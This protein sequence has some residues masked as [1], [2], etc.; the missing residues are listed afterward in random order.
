MAL[1]TYNAKRDFKKTSEPSGKPPARKAKGKLRFVV[2]KHDASHLHYDFRLEMEGVLRSWAV[3]KGFPT[4]KGDKRLAVHVEDH[5]MAYR[6]FEGTIPAGN[7]GGGTVMVW[8]TGTYEVFGTDPV[9]AYREGKL[10]LQL[11]GGKLTGEWTL[12]AMRGRGEKNW[13]LLKSGESVKEFTAA[14]EN[15]SSKTRR[16]FEEIA[17][18]DRPA[19]RWDGSGQGKGAKADR[20]SA[21]EAPK[22]KAKVK[23]KVSVPR[24]R[25]PAPTKRSKK[26]PVEQ[27]EFPEPPAGLPRGS[28]AFVPPMK[29]LLVE[30]LPV[31]KEWLYEIKFDGYRALGIKRTSGVQLI[32]RNQKPF[33][34]PDVLEALERLKASEVV[35]DG[36]IIATDEEGRSSF[37]SLQGYDVSGQERP[38]LFFY[39]F[40]LLRWNGRDLT[41]LPLV[42]RKALLAGLV[43]EDDPVLRLSAAIESDPQRLVAEARRRGLEGIIAKQWNGPYAAG[44]RGQG[45]V[46][47]KILQ[48]QEFVI[49]GYTEPVGSREYFGALLVGVQGPEGL[50]FAS[51]VGTGFD[52]KTLAALHTRFRN[53]SVKECPFVNLPQKKSGRY[54]QGL[55]SAEMRRCQWIKPALVCQVKFTEWTREG[56]LRH[57]VYLGLRSDKPPADV[58]REVPAP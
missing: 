33:H 8:D 20:P 26:K 27:T 24:A 45:W 6:D 52:R 7:Y 11:D 36:E 30:H 55:T 58:V 10:H 39:L 9:T 15:Q 35:V 46:K 38:P 53:L 43:P 29:C 37:Q 41:G 25:E 28:T 16:S 14:Q 12:V 49:G 51:R 21:P 48:E 40:D 50:E 56:G 22:A 42:E 54:S 2:Q 57:P 17:K 32:S 3:P 1:E 47:F 19:A 4:Q 44:A 34:Y 23:K 31:G 13:L 18:D 5:P